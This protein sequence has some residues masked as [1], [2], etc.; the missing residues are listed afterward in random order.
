MTPLYPVYTGHYKIIR[1]H[2]QPEGHS[3]YVKR[4]EAWY[5]DEILLRTT[6][7]LRGA[8]RAVRADKRRRGTAPPADEVVW[9][10]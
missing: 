5:K 8:K 3:G 2:V 6:F 10:G 9:R 4:Y 7:T 1:V